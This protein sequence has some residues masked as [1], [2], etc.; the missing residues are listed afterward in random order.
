MAINTVSPVGNRE[1]YYTHYYFEPD[2]YY[3][4]V[5][6]SPYYYGKRAGGLGCLRR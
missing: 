1:V 6:G 2:H 4:K 5:E 3:Y